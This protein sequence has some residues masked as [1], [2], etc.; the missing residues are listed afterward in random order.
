MVS[1]SAFLIKMVVDMLN[2]N[3]SLEALLKLL[4][5]RQSWPAK[6]YGS[7]DNK[8]L[9]NPSMYLRYLPS[10]ITIVLLYRTRYL[11]VPME[12]FDYIGIAHC[13]G[14]QKR[15]R[16]KTAVIAMA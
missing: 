2:G 8:V 13:C 1:V 16:T 14:A 3:V 9:T 5:V 15:E 10:K 12:D 11:L 4:S 7:G 6:A